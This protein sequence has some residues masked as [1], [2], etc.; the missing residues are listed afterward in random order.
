[1]SG[2]HCAIP[3]PRQQ[4]NILNFLFHGLDDQFSIGR[5]DLD[6]IAVAN[7]TIENAAGNTVLNLSLDDALERTRTILRVVALGCQQVF[8][9]ITE[10]Q[11][12]MTVFQAWPQAIDLDL[13]NA[14][15]LIAGDLMEDD[16]FIDTVDEF[17]AQAL[18]TQALSYHALHLL[19]VHAIEF[20]QPA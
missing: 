9:C 6:C 7:G 20:G 13:Y 5:I 12:D 16:Y 8:R 2:Q 4:R 1:M 3:D 14:L 17:W 11:C 15:H 10:V 18:F 19:L